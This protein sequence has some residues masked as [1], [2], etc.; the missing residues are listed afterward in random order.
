MNEEIKNILNNID[1]N[2]NKLIKINNNL[3]LT[4]NQI[5]ILKRYKIDYETS[6]SLRDLMIKIENILD[7][8]EEI[9]ELVDLLDKLSERN[10]YEFTNK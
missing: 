6:N 7:Y 9:P 2:N 4:N 8:E 1:F 5:D 10:Y 3:Y